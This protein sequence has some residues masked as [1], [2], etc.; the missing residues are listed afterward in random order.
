MPFC[1]QL[2]IALSGKYKILLFRLVTTCRMPCCC[3]WACRNT[4][5]TLTL[6]I[7]IRIIQTCCRKLLYVRVK[8]LKLGKVLFIPIVISSINFKLCRCSYNLYG[9]F[10]TVGWTQNGTHKS[11]LSQLSLSLSLSLW[12]W[13]RSLIMSAA[14]RLFASETILVKHCP[15]TGYWYSYCWYNA[16]SEIHICILCYFLNNSKTKIAPNLR[17]DWNSIWRVRF[18]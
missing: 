11:G 4:K 2:Y 7:V 5:C 16:F 14:N 1:V 9:N 6:S 13:P 8:S 17:Q 15:L 12:L 3:A 10:T 18:W